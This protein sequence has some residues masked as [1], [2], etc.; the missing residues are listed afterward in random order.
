MGLVIIFSLV[1]ILAAYGSFTS[2][3]N[4]NMLGLV[5]A[6]GSFLV[7]GWFAVMTLLNSGYPAGH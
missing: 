7:F 6:G 2:L 3:K 4:K 1:A 5:F